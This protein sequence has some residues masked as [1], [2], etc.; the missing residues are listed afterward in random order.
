MWVSKR[1]LRQ[2]LRL[3]RAARE[4]SQREFEYLKMEVREWERKY[5]RLEESTRERVPGFWVYHRESS[6]AGVGKKFVQADRLRRGDDYVELLLEGK[7]V[8][9]I[10]KS[11]LLLIERGEN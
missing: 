3:E 4:A 11:E 5:E 1:E 10:S 9:T 6:R 2:E 8:L 7:M